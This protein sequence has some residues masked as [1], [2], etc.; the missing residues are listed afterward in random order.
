MIRFGKKGKLSPRYV[1]PYEIV[2]R[3]RKVNY[4]LKLPSKLAP[5]HPIFHVSMLK[6]F[7]GDPISILPIEGLGVN[8][9]LAY[10]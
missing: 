5:V 9:N 2:K 6:K 3:V 10:E 4:K 8:E 7:I 1:G